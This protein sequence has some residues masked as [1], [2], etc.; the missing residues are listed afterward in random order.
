MNNVTQVRLSGSGGQGIVLAGLLLGE[1][2]ASDGKYVAGGN[3]YGAQARGSGCRSDVILSDEPVDFPHLI[4]PDY[5]IAMS[6]DTY[7][8]YGEELR[9]SGGV[10]LFDPAFVTP[11]SATPVREIAV[12]AT[13]HAVKVLNNQQMANLVLLGAF[14]E[15]TGIV[16][17]EACRKAV[18][19]HVKERFRELNFK[20]FEEGMELGRKVNG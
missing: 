4:T 12:Q 19:M 7:D 11:K 8:L 17:R 16:S 15:I 10:V 6:Q 3:F 9:A 13:E 20:A 14:I 2:G 5:L 18:T 1:A